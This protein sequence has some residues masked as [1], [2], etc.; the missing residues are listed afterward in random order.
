VHTWFNGLRAASGVGQGVML[1]VVM[2]MAALFMASQ[3]GG[4]VLLYALLLG[5]VFHFLWSDIRLQPGIEFCARTLLRAGVALMGL[6]I[7]LDQVRAL[8]WASGLLALSGMV[9]TITLGVWMARWLRRP[10]EEGWIS[11]CAVGVCGVSAALAVSAAMPATRE[12]QR[13]TLLA[14]VGVTVMSTLAMLVYPAVVQV[15]GLAPQAAGVFF[16]ASIHDVAQVVAAGMLMAE[17]GSSVAADNATVVKLFR[18]MLLMPVVLLVTWAFRAE[19]NQANASAQ[20]LAKRPPWVPGFLM[21]FGV[22]MVVQTL[23]WVPPAVESVAAKTSQVLLVLAIVAAG[24]KTSVADLFKLGWTPVVI[25]GAETLFLAI[26]VGAF[27]LLF[28]AQS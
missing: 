6:R 8:G 24:I 25:L 23:G 14:V 12:N 18:V 9:L 2:A 11:G 4:P 16:G 17:G 20:D 13:F 3:H 7:G 26:W 5:L 15:M 21:V 28:G 22:F 10:R 27:L 1:C 19:R